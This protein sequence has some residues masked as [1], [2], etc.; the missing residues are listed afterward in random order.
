MNLTCL[1]LRPFDDHWGVAVPASTMR[2]Y[3]NGREITQHIT[4]M[5]YYPSGLIQPI[6]GAI[7]QHRYDMINTSEL[8]FTADGALLV[9]A[10]MGCALHLDTRYAASDIEVEFRFVAP[11]TIDVEVLGSE[12]FTFHSYSGPGY[13]GEL[14]PLQRQLIDYMGNRHDK[15]ELSVPEDADYVWIKFPPMPVGVSN[16]GDVET[17]LRLPSS[18][19]YRLATGVSTLSVDHTITMG[20][21]LDGQWQDRDQAG[22]EYLRKLPRVSMV[23]APEYFVPPGVGFDPCM[24]EG[25]CPDSLLDQIA[26]ATA[27]M[28]IYYYRVTRRSDDLLRIPLRAVG[29]DW[30]PGEARTAGTD[31]PTVVDVESQAYLPFLSTGPEPVGPLPPDDPTGCPCGWFTSDGRMVDYIPGP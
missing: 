21:P 29:P 22:G 28:T 19:T 2:A 14:E 18:G 1:G 9:P 27:E 15:K 16:F 30:D 26:N 24:V 23:A 20:L 6:A 8:D 5:I 11:Q 17:N 25:G 31:A 4:R 13:S 7:N 12:A 3:S 10:N